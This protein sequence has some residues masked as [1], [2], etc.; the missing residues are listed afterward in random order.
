MAFEICEH[1]IA[2]GGYRLAHVLSTI[3]EQIK[4]NLQEGFIQ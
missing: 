2:L 4:K 3:Y 1:N